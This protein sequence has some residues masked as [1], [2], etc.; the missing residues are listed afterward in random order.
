MQPEWGKIT[1]AEL[2]SPIR[3]R[4]VSGKADVAFA[5]LST[6]SRSAG[7]GDLFWALRGEKFDGH[8][9]VRD[10]VESGVSGVVVDESY[11]P[12]L[13]DLAQPDRPAVLAVQDTLEALGDLAGWW[14]RQFDISV[15]AITGSMGKTTTKEM[16]AAVLGR[17]HR[18]LK[19]H[20]NFNNL[21]GVPLTL[22]RLDDTVSRVILELGM[23]HPGEIGRLTRITDPQLGVITNVGKVHLEGLGDVKEVAKA[24]CELIEES[25]PGTDIG[26]NG[27]D[28]VL[29]AAARELRQDL[30]TFG[31]GPQ[32]RVYADGI[33]QGTPEGISFLLH[34]RGGAWPV[35]LKVPG[36]HNVRNAVAAAA[37]SFLAD[38]DPEQV[39]QGLEE[40]RGMKGRFSVERLPSGITVIDDTYNSNPEALLAALQ[41]AQSLVPKGGRL[42]AGFGDMLE[43]GEA[44]PA[45]HKTAGR[46][47]AESGAGVLVVLGD[48]AGDVIEGAREAGFP[49][50]HMALAETREQMA[51]F[52]ALAAGEGDVVL[53]KASRAM[54]LGKAVEL[55]KASVEQGRT[56]TSGC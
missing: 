23:N 29:M 39:V 34:Y 55:F 8:D 22:L 12:R 35:S 27:D 54:D 6:D 45:E 51:E 10:A 41:T 2:I 33:T 40:F 4:L 9:F 13:R 21:I 19:S 1:S 31:L 25:A 18:V 32:N 17:E 47:V 11:L 20:G 14:R 26:V 30:F 50:K 44:A 38:A 42:L 7:A 24:K 43:L 28:R 46:L 16:C 15:V 56:C 36:R 3:G 5:G 49:A 48:Y 37:A 53:F 52:L